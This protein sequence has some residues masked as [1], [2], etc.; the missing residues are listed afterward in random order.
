[1]VFLFFFLVI[2]EALSL[3]HSLAALGVLSQQRFV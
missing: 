1:L 2:E 3:P